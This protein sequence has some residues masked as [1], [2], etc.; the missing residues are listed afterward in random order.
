MVAHS[1]FRRRGTGYRTESS[2][3]SWS[4]K[5]T[6]GSIRIDRK[7]RVSVNSPISKLIKR[8]QLLGLLCASGLAQTAPPF[9]CLSP[10]YH[11]VPWKIVTSDL[12]S[13]WRNARGASPNELPTSSCGSMAPQLLVSVPHRDG[14]HSHEVPI[15]QLRDTRAFFFV[16]GM[17]IDADGAPNAYNPDD[18]GL[19]ALANAGSP[20]HWD[21][22]VSDREENPFIQQQ[23]DPF[24]GYYVSCT[25][26]ADRTKNPADPTRYVDA[27]KVPYV[28]LPKEV[29]DRG[30]A[31]LGDFAMVMNLRN[32]RFSFAIYADMGTLGE[33][34][35]ALANALGIRSDARQGGTSGRILYVLFPGS[36]NL[37]PRT[38]E[39][40]QSEG[41][42]LL[43]R[44]GGLKNLSSCAG[45]GGVALTDERAWSPPKN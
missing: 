37:R 4:I 7:L 15:W 41:E 23:T 28:V 6:I 26:L 38:I 24:P 34:S 10:G 33:G 5:N 20:S 14:D 22:I 32:G 29:A 18:T 1:N 12:V 36:G 11:S 35:V 27:A 40:I 45:N 8:V 43:Y 21:G 39:E 3:R 31:R 13:E 9:L 30:A 16:S 17:T 44:A 25:S 19:D 42:K 2:D